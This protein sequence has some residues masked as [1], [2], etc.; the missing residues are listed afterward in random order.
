MAWDFS[1]FPPYLKLSAAT[2]IGEVQVWNDADDLY[3]KYVS[4]GDCF[5]ETHLHVADSLSGI[6]QTKN[7]NPIP[8]QFEHSDPHGC[9]TEYTYQL[10]LDWSTGTGLFIAAHAALGQQEAIAIVSGDGSTMVT[11]RRS[12]NV[13]GPFTPLN[14]AAV[15]AWEPGPAYPNDGPDD[16]GW[17][18][19]S[20][21]D[22]NLSINM[23]PTGAD[24]IW[25]SYQVL[26]P[27]YGTVLTFQRSFDIGEPIAGNLKIA[28]DNGYEV[29]LNGAPLGDDNVYGV[30]RPSDLK[31]AFVDVNGWNAVGSYDLGGDLLAGANVLTIDVANEYFDT[32]D[33]GNGAPGTVSSNPGACIFAMDVDH[34][35][36]G[37]TAWAAG[38]D[39][40]GKNWATYFEYTVQD[41]TIVIAGWD[42][43]R[44]GSY[45][46]NNNAA[47][48]SDLEGIYSDVEFPELNTLT[49][50]NLANV[51]VVVLSSVYAN[52]GAITPL[53]GD[54]QDALLGFVEGGGCALLFPD[55]NTFAGNAD[56]VNESLID[57]FGLDI[58]GTLGGTYTATVTGAASPV[59]VG[60][61]TYEGFYGGWF[62]TL[63]GATVL[64]ELPNNED[65]L[66]EFAPDH[67]GGGSGR[68]VVFSD[69]NV[70]FAAGNKYALASNQQLF[71]NSVDAC[72]N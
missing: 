35:A 33:S 26:D 56:L 41:P 46:L 53:T 4:N 19:N 24:W 14:Q 16:S 62:N 13:V 36:D 52:S 10:D 34:Y 29:F 6:P 66:V 47:A 45:R 70:F 12:G 3:V 40:P 17:E 72:F 28:C 51:D 71:L 69:A 64:A 55:N 8:G 1:S 25:E 7:G 31:Q 61:A 68:V 20:L 43:A 15:L 11:Q 38:T 21:W 18:A 5:L 23:I 9:V 54:E 37:E 63:N 50:A 39:F 57:P 58:T 2:V 30:W 48:T 65:G 27:I 67:F 22:Q 44:G 42:A 32:D 49:D 60:V 59:T